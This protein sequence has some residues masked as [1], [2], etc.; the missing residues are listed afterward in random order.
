MVTTERR[1][2]RRIA[3]DLW[4]SLRPNGIDLQKPNHYAEMARTVWE[5]RRNLPYAWRILSKGVCDGCALGVAGF[6]DWTI[7]GIH[8]CTTRLNL[9]QA[10]HHGRRST[11]RAWPMSRPCE[12]S[13]ARSCASSAAC[14]TRCSADAASPASRRIS[15]DE[16]LDLA[17]SRVR[18]ARERAGADGDRIGFY[19]TARGLT[20][21]V[22]YVAQ[23]V[24]RFLGTNSVDNAARICHAPST[25]ALRARHRGGRHDRARTPTSSS[26]PRRPLRRRCRR[27]R[28]R[29]S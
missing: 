29:S 2:A 9:L 24:A 3:P 18:S 25:G 13:A 22:Y 26:G 5:N 17:A 6:H 15:W 12:S 20:N 21:E 14:R 10:Q 19:L 8:L 28:S 4:V 11:R 16:A 7:D 23:K 1:K 27:T